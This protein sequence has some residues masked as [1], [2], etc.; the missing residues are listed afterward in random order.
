MNADTFYTIDYKGCWI[1]SHYDR[2]LKRE[3][4][5]IQTPS[6][7]SYGASSLQSAKVRIT[8]FLSKEAA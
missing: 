2:D 3:V 1:H 6:G 5:R 4:F 8:R 7:A